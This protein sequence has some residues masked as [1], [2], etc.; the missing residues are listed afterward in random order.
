MVIKCSLT[1]MLKQTLKV[2]II[3][4][5][6]T[7]PL[8]PQLLAKVATMEVVTICLEVIAEVVSELLEQLTSH[9]MFPN[10]PVCTPG[11]HI[12]TEVPRH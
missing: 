2:L 9:Q 5:I 7:L 6:F 8:L 3:L 12:L 1:L 4:V 11:K 10:S